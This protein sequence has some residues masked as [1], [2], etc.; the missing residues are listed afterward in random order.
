MGVT[1][2]PVLKI[3]VA[4]N[5]LEP[6]YRQCSNGNLGPTCSVSRGLLRHSPFSKENAKSQS[7]NF[8]IQRNSKLSPSSQRSFPT[9]K[10]FD[11]CKS[12]S[13]SAKRAVLGRSQPYDTLLSQWQ[14]KSQA[15]ATTTT[16]AAVRQEAEDVDSEEEVAQVMQGVLRRYQRP[17]E[18]RCI[19]GVRRFKEGERDED[20]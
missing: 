2:R 15:K 20:V 4:A 11:Q 13:M 19:V 9:C 6:L 12:H 1:E 3:E 7:T 5:R 17:L 18:Q 14:R 16:K 10:I 8:L